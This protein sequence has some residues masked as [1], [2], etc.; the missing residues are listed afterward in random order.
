MNKPIKQQ[1]QKQKLRKMLLADYE[2]SASTH[3]SDSF[4][5]AHQRLWMKRLLEVIRAIDRDE[6]LPSLIIGFSE[7]MREE[8]VLAMPWAK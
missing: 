4:K 3:E 8:G 7:V 6:E 2:K 1:K 5:A